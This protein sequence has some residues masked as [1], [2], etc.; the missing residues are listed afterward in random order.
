[1]PGLHFKITG[2]VQGVGFRYAMCFEARRLRLAGWVRNCFDGSVEAVAVGDTVALQRL[3]QWARRGPPAAQVR[4]AQI[5]P[6]NAAQEGDVD[7]PFNERP[8]A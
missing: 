1:M 8:S 3:A 6:A 7:E 4:D 5:R 2:R